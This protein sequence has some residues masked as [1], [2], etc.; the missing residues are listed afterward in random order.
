MPAL[1]AA[2]GEGSLRWLKVRHA[3]FLV[4]L[5]GLRLLFDPW[6]GREPLTGVALSAPQPVPSVD[7][8]GRVDLLFITS[9]RWDRFD[10]FSLRKLG[11]RDA[12]CFVPDEDCARRLRSA[13]Y[14]RVRVTRA[15][16]EWRHGDVTIQVSAAAEG[17][18][19]RVLRRGRSLWNAGS[20]VPLDVDD[21]PIDFARRRPSEVVF[22]GWDPGP[23][24]R[25]GY[26][27][28]KDDALLLAQLARARFVV[29]QADD[30]VPTAP[31]RVAAGW[32]LGYDDEPRPPPGGPRVVRPERGLWYRVARRT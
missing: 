26:A 22:S 27:I 14:Q 6:F 10:P 9:D 28:G 17:V 8:V 29:P 25:W 32:A 21:A 20:L 30:V 15:G 1:A 23:G 19:Y 5:D 16:D 3:T 7:G 13:G 24:A 4:E 11:G 12:Y 18:G 31:L 2:S